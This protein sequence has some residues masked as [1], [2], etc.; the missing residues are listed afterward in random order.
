MVIELQQEKK[1]NLG[2]LRFP[3]KKLE[4]VNEKQNKPLI[5]NSTHRRAANAP[6]IE[7]TT[8]LILLAV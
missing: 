2:I 5:K 1:W 6:G 7:K 3:A 4:S 8:E